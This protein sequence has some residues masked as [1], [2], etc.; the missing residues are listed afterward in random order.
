M[1]LSLLGDF[2][3]I[4]F[5]KV[6]FFLNFQFIYSLNHI[7]QNK[8]SIQLIKGTLKSQFIQEWHSSVEKSTKCTNHKIFKTTFLVLLILPKDLRN[9]FV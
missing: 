9:A 1:N 5:D 7:Y 8:Q 6:Q 3:D 4:Q 2:R